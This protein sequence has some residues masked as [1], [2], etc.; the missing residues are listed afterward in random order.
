MKNRLQSYLWQ[1][2]ILL[3]NQNPYLPALEDIGCTW[4]QVTELI[5]AHQLFYCKAFKKRTTYLSP[6]AYYLLKSLRR[7]RP[8]SPDA[9]RIF[10]LLRDQPPAETAFLKRMAEL[11]AKRYGQAFDFLLQNLYV[12]ALQNG[13]DLNPHWSTF[14]YGT[15]QAWEALTPPALSAADAEAR[16]WELVG[17]T[18]QEK[19]YRSFIR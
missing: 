6:E 19:E 8:M 16:L 13:T 4:R 18:M 1:N 12:T 3:C 10:A 11:P 5:D 17:R 15:A 7:P 14:L 2:G 9:E